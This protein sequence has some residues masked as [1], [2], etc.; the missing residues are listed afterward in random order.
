[1]PGAGRCLR[2]AALAPPPPRGDGQRQD[3]PSEL[4]VGGGDTSVA[5]ASVPEGSRRTLAGQPRFWYPFFLFKD[6]DAGV[7]LRPKTRKGGL[8]ARIDTCRNAYKMRHQFSPKALRGIHGIGCLP[9][10]DVTL[11]GSRPDSPPWFQPD[12]THGG[13]QRRAHRTPGNRSPFWQVSLVFPDPR[14][15]GQKHEAGRIPGKQA[16]TN[17]KNMNLA[18]LRAA[19][20]RP[21][22]PGGPEEARRR[23]A[24]RP[25]RNPVAPHDT[26]HA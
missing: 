11:P 8:P 21:T 4:P 12:S 14:R 10:R 9:A 7:S 17:W 19:R 13:A 15:T 22:S 6:F 5:G 25:G 16:N 20:R 23:P 18:H 1:M 24:T 2:G 3:L 26:E